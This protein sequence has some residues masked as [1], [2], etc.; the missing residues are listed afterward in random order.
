M[1]MLALSTAALGADQ[2]HRKALFGE[3]H[4][5]TSWSFDAFLFGTR[6]TPDDAYRF[7][8]GGV[9]THPS[10]GSYQLSRPLDFLAVTDHG[11]YMGAFPQMANPNHPLFKTSLAKKVNSTDPDIR[12]SAF[13]AIVKTILDKEQIEELANPTVAQTTW[14]KMIESANRHYVAGKFTTLIGY[15]WTSTP[16]MKNLHRNVLFRGDSAPLPFTLLDSLHPEDLW[17]WMDSE[18]DKGYQL[19]AIPH[20]SNLSDGAMFE[21]VDSWGKSLTKNYAEQRLRNEP[22]VEITQVK[23]TSETHPSLSPNDEFAGFELVE[24]RVATK[25]AITRFSGSY[26]RD[27]LRTGLEMDNKDNFNPYQFGF[28]GSTDSHTGISPLAENN[29]SGKEG[30]KD[31]S[32]ERRL[33]S[34]SVTMDV[35]KF[36]ASGL[37]AVWA[38]ENTRE[39]VYD[40]LQRKESWATTGPRIQLRFFAGWDLDDINLA[41]DGWVTAAYKAGVSMG[42]VLTAAQDTA[43]PSFILWA[44]KDVEGANLDRI[45]IVKGWSEKG[46]SQEKIYNIVLSDDRKVDRC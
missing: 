11:V 22:V 19:M 23:G 28:I 13:S 26:V 41:E 45:Q 21:R 36:S 38:N 20:N 42:G 31:G 14:D 6:A 30:V 44:V 35:S 46:I 25:I 18:R 32:P 9:L 43:L 37:V 39:Q 29:Y 17:Q 4:M 8:K 10:G 12:L 33:Q 7:A 16:D 2:S 24:Q 34:D 40:A 27:A 1:A 5:H 3:L 15:E